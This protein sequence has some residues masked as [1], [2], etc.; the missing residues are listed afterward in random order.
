MP[1]SNV[2]IRA[3]INANRLVFDPPIPDSPLDDEDNRIGSSSVDLLLHEELI[4]LPK[5]RVPGITID[6][7]VAD[8]E[9]MD[10]LRRNGVIAL[11][12]NGAV[13]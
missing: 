6:P 5:D 11:S 8:I 13:R 12:S 9:I 4:I 2:E 1:L 10:I 7:S 3:E